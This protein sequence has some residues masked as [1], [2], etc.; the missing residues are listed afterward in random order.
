MKTEKSINGAG[1]NSVLHGVIVRD[2]R[3]TL[4]VN[5]TKR[6]LSKHVGR[7]DCEGMPLHDREIIEESCVRVIDFM[8]GKYG[9][10]ESTFYLNEKGSPMFDTI[11]ALVSHY[12]AR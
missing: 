7:F 9:K 11:E 4:H 2:F 5:L 1:C 8:A 3:E 6:H 12:H 10:S